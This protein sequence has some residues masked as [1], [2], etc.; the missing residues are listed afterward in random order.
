MKDSRNKAIEVTDVWFSYDSEQILADI[1]FSIPQGSITALIGPNGSGKTTLL[2]VMLGFLEPKQGNVSVLGSSPKIARKKVGYVPQRFDFDRTF[3]IT[4]A[5]LLE[6]S[7]PTASEEKIRQYLAHL[8]MEHVLPVRIGELSGGQLQ[9][10]LIARAMLH[11]P[12]ILFLDEPVS[13]IDVGGEQTFY[14]LVSH[15]HKEHGTTMIMVSHEIDVV[16]RFADQVVCINRS[17]LCNGS[18]NSVVTPELIEKLYGE[19][20]TIYAHDK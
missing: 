10:V 7:H 6:F 16:Q 12:S 11:D 15:L 18:P 14:Q 4:V 5:E 1:T 8:G 2:K 17:L 13:G 9:R 19:D 3:P 20:A